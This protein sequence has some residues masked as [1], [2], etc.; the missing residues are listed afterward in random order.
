MA[1]L[2]YLTFILYFIISYS[3]IIPTDPK[4]RKNHKKNTQKNLYIYIYDMMI[5]FYLGV[6]IF[7]EF[8]LLL[9]ND[10]INIVDA[11]FMHN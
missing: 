6:Y 10:I 2:Q 7:F 3:E 11:F 5:I 9:I 8:V 1:A 4:C